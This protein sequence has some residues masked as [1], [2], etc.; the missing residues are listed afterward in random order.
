VFKIVIRANSETN[1]VE[2][3]NMFSFTLRNIMFE[4][5]NNYMGD[6]TNCILAE[7]QLT[8]CKIYKKVKK[9]ETREE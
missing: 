9:H 6:Y 7:L 3:V 5:C 4:L 2:I 1:D 8:F